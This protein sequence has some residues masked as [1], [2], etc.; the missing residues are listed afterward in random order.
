M[1]SIFINLPITEENNGMAPTNIA[2]KAVPILGTATDK[3]INWIDTEVTP[4]IA[5]CFAPIEK[6][7]FF[8]IIKPS[9]MP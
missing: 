2:V 9:K 3:P 4:S 5:K 7:N 6:S 8:L 1:F